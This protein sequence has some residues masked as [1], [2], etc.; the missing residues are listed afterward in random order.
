MVLYIIVCLIVAV[1]GTVQAADDSDWSDYDAVVLEAKGLLD[2]TFTRQMSKE[3]ISL[4]IKF[5]TAKGIE[6]Y[7]THVLHYNHGLENIG[8]I[9]GTVTLPDGKIVKITKS[10]ILKKKVARRGS[11]KQTE[12]KIAFPSLEVGAV[13]DF[14]YHLTFNGTR[15]VSWW[16]FQREL[17]TVHSE[18]GFKPWPGSKWG[19]SMPRAK[20]DPETNET[21][22]GGNNCYTYIRRNIEPLPDEPKSLAYSSQC[23]SITFYYLDMHFAYDNYWK[24]GIASVYKQYFKEMIKPSSKAKKII[25]THFSNV[26]PNEEII[27]M[28]YDYVIQ[29]FVPVQMLTLEESADLDEDILEDVYEAD[30]NSKLFRS[31]YVTDWQASYVLASLIQAARKDAQVDLVFC[32]PWDEDLFDPNLKTV[33]QFHDILVRATYQNKTYWMCPFKR[34]LPINGTDWALKGVKVVSV[35]SKTGK[36]EKIPLDKAEDNPSSLTGNVTFDPDE[37]TARLVMTEVY[38][39]Y[40]SYWWRTLMKTLSSDEERKQMLETKIQGRYGDDATLNNYTVTHLDDYSQPLTIMR[41]YT[42]PY[43]FE[44]LGDQILMDFPGFLTPS[45]NPFDAP[46]RHNQ[47]CFRYPFLETQAITYTIPEGFSIVS[48]PDA[49]STLPGLYSYNV[50]YSKIADN[51]LKVSSKAKLKGNMMSNKAA[52][53]LRSVYNKVLELQRH[54]LVLKED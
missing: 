6:D 25:K 38:N 40:D 49:L 42:I 37:G 45:S 41:D 15:G 21:R 20:A 47:I 5:L 19:C 23:E 43:E 12:V 24:D 36:I 2:H 54:K 33:K 14:S 7:G 53:M 32:I 46:E 18:V 30:K 1:A 3:T 35:N 26:G 11:R 44:E 4:K 9:E 16:P 8:D 52:A 39:Q 50:D 48:T 27:P 29:N 51:Q 31:K 22:P 28:I 34:Y 10:D 17:Y 13:V